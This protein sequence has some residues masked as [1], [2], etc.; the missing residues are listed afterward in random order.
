MIVAVRAQCQKEGKKTPK[1]PTKHIATFT[2]QKES[3]EITPSG[4]PKI[5]YTVLYIISQ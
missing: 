4:R 5:Y 2:P 3:K 1:I